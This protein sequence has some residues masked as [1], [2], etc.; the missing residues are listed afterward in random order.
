M[1]YDAWYVPAVHE[2]GHAVIS[3]VLGRPILHA[4]LHDKGKGEVVPNCS[5]SA[6]EISHYEN[7]NP[8]TDE[9]S[10]RIQEEIFCDCGIAVSGVIA[11]KMICGDTTISAEE[12]QGDEEKSRNKAAYL[13]LWTV[14]ACCNTGK[15]KGGDGCSVCN[16]YLKNL[17]KL[18][19]KII[20]KPT[21]RDAIE[22]LAQRLK[23]LRQM[24]G[25]EIKV[26]LNKQGVA[27]GSEVQEFLRENVNSSA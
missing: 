9:R 27:F 4:V 14:G 2:A 5:H 16:E 19:K 25:E 18:V 20:S 10:R 12:I 1:S 15:G 17:R 22:K 6:D 13:H 8:E 26:F 21:I 23:D 24:N 3:H 11:E 7:N